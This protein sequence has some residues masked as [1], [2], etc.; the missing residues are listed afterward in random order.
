MVFFCFEVL[1]GCNPKTGRNL[2]PDS[3]EALPGR[4]QIIL[5]RK[6][7]TRL[8]ILIPVQMNEFILSV[9]QL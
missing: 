5:Y 4:D 2:L 8:F 3:L 9:S 1:T 6:I 7:V